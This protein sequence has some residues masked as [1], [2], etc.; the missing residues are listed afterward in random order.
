MKNHNK[1]ILSL[2]AVALLGIGIPSAAAQT[3]GCQYNYSAGI[4]SLSTDS[5]EVKV[6]GVNEA[7]HFHWWDPNNPD[8][9]YHMRFVSLFEINDTNDDGI[10][11]RHVDH[12]VGP[13]F[14][15]AITNWEF[16]GFVTDMDGENI[17]AVH[18][19]FTT[20]AGF[21]PRPGSQFTDLPDLNEFDVMVQLR[22]HF[23]MDNPSEV[24]FDVI[25][26]GWNWTYEGNLLIL[27]FTIVES[28][29]GQGQ[30]EERPRG[31]QRDGT[32]YN[33]GGGFMDYEETAMAAQ[34]TLQVRSSYGEGFA[35]ENGEAIYLAFEY[36]GDEKLEYDP[37]IGIRYE[38][39]VPLETTLLVVGG[40]VAVA[41]LAIVLKFKK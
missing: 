19:N 26:D 7:P 28:N 22:I 5:F 6:T 31:F 29:H 3:N 32:K 40:I 16:S 11:T 1:V 9:E 30:P 39:A 36:F 41:A 14:M 17:T 37:I 34:N 13:R 35:F 4:V 25:I 18:F 2:L 12:I 10:F 20:T 8:V 21:D 23:Y 33:F 24:K 27:Q 15:L 38:S